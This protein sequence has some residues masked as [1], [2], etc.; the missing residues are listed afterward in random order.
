[1]LKLKLFITVPKVL[2]LKIPIN[3]SK[4]LNVHCTYVC[5]YAFLLLHCDLRR[6]TFHKSF[7]RCVSYRCCHLVDV[8]FW[9][10]VVDKRFRF[11]SKKYSTIKEHFE[12]VLMAY[13]ENTIY[14]Y[15]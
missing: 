7:C 15:N 13:G 8:F 4:Y 5:Q 3:T 11:R 10:L 14:I 2:E 12:V 1:M 9:F 6:N